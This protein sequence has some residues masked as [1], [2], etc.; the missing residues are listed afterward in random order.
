MQRRTSSSARRY[1]YW[2]LLIPVV[3]M[4]WIPSYNRLEPSL[5]GVPFFYWYQFLWIALTSLVTL[6]VYLLAYS[7]V[8]EG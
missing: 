8:D 3:A 2:L 7:G 4:L 5:A 1:W 6:V